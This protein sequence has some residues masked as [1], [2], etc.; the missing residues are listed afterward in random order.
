MEEFD[1]LDTN[2]HILKWDDDDHEWDKWCVA[3]MD[4]EHGIKIKS[5]K[6]NHTLIDKKP[7]QVLQGHYI[8]VTRSLL[9]KVS[10]WNKNKVYW[11][12]GNN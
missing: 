6:I 3:N 12:H 7:L 11:S 8:P 10:D 2:C 1:S 5:G 9:R 4:F